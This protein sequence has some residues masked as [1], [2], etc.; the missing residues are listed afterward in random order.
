M[1][2]TFLVD[3]AHTLVAPLALH[4]DLALSTPAETLPAG[5][6]LVYRG[7][8]ELE[9]KPRYVFTHQGAKRYTADRQALEGALVED[10]DA[11]VQI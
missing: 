11:L 6:T 7:V 2:F 8:V 10:Y 1:A 9:G 4:A 5:E 3:R